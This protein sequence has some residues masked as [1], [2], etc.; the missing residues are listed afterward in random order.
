MNVETHIIIAELRC[1]FI[2][3]LSE[4]N[5]SAK[6]RT[7]MKIQLNLVSIFKVLCNLMTNT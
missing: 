5:F 7:K 1:F 3:L 6:R 2:K 4:S